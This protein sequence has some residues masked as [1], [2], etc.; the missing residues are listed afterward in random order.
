LSYLVPTEVNA[1]DADADVYQVHSG[2]QNQ[3]SKPKQQPQQRRPQQQTRPSQGNAS[4]PVQHKPY[5]DNPPQAQAK[6]KQTV[7]VNQVYRE[8]TEAIRRCQS[9][10]QLKDA[11]KRY[12]ST[13]KPHPAYLEPINR[14]K[15]EM[16]ARFGY[17]GQKG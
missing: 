8:A 14:L 16:K 10:H 12:Y 4:Q 5:C 15:D 9:S 11:Y 7:D 3:Q 13:L 2:S 6:P 17:Q 1:Q